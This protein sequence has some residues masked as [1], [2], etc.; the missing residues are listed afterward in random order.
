[1]RFFHK[2]DVYIILMLT[3]GIPLLTIIP[4]FNLPFYIVYPAQAIGIVLTFLGLAASMVS[5]Q[6]YKLNSKLK[7]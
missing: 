6:S 5:L 3:I 1:M 2:L 7:K 4:I